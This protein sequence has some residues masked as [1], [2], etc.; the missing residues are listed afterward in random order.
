MADLGIADHRHGLR[1]QRRVALDEI[2][3]FNV[4]VLGERTDGDL[5]TPSSRTYCSSS[6]FEMSMTTSGVA[7]R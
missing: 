4:D 6:I 3:G 5:V 7:K 2:V 1:E